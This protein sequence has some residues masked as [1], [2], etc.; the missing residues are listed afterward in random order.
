[1]G[2]AIMG[3]TFDPVHFGHLRSAVEVRQAL[4]VSQVKLIPVGIPAHRERPG[5]TPEQRLEMLRLSTEEVEYLQIDDREISRGGTSYMM[6][7]LESVRTEVGT[8]LSVSLVLGIDAFGLIHQWHRWREL[9]DV[10]HLVVL[11]RPVAAPILVPEVSE[12]IAGLRADVVQLLA[13]PAGLVCELQLTQLDIS[14]T[15][16]RQYARAGEPI[17]YL[18]PAGVIKYIRQ[19]ALYREIT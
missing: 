9:L 15:Q 17:D 11:R 14:S 4:G 1:M 7:T 8:D 13:Q 5:S 6:D 12:W 18:L 10:A 19:Q 16:I 3:G 2:L